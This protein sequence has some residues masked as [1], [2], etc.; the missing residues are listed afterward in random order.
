LLDL[1]KL[2]YKDP[3]LLSSTDGVGTKLKIAIQL[4]E[5]RFL[6]YDLV[7]M[8][9]NDILANGGEPLFFLDYIASSKIKNDEFLQLIT[10]INK[11]CKDAGCSLVG[12][13]TAEMPGMYKKNDFD[14][15]GFSVGVVERMNLLGEKK[16][17][18]DFLIIGL[19]SNGFHSNGF[20]LIRKIIKTKKI[21]LTKTP[22]YKSKFHSLGIDLLQP[23]TIFVKSVLPLIKNN[24]IKAISHI[25]GGGIFE[26]LERIIPENML[27]HIN[28]KQFSIPESFLWIKEIG[29][30]K[31]KEMLKTFNCGIGL[32]LIID[33]KNS[34][35]VF[36]YFKKKK[37]NFHI[38]VKITSG[39]KI[40][41][42]VFIENFGTWDLI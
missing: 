12:G 41:K 29:K 1:K 10:S 27:A 14:I 19:D 21:S 35:N 40:K 23:T 34:T 5:L 2:N 7:G 26:N 6:G 31:K 15:A 9:V 37:I 3:I 18:K 36:Y 8:C 16:V 20:S 4:K 32:I 24:Y 28:F 30:I 13:E 42:K 38:M 39:K 33:P 17:K 25:T 11:A 22:P